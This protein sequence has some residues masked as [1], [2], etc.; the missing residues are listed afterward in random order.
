MSG[1][2]VRRRV[3]TRHRAVAAAGL[4]L[5]LCSSCVSPVEEPAAEPAV[6]PAA[7]AAAEPAPP[8]VP[9]PSEPAQTGW[10]ADQPAEWP[11]EWLAQQKSR[12]ETPAEPGPEAPV[13]RDVEAEEEAASPPGFVHGS[14]SLRYRDQETGSERDRDLYALLDLEMGDEDLDP[15]TATIVGR[16]AQDFGD[17]EP[18]FASPEDTFASNLTAQL[19]EAHIDLHDVPSLE[20]V[21]LGRQELFETPVWVRYDGLQLE[22]VP[23]G[24]G[25]QTYGFYGGQSVHFWESS[26]E[27]DAVFGAWWVDHPW[28]GGRARLD[29]MHVEDETLTG[30][31][32]DDLVAVQLR[33]DVGQSTQLQGDYSWLGQTPRDLRLGALWND[34]EEGVVVQGTLYELLSTQ[35]ELTEELDPFSPTLF[36]Q[37]PYRQLRASASKSWDDDFDLDGGADVRRVTDESDV[38][39]FNRDFE[40]YYLTATK[41]DAFTDDLSLGLTGELW[42]SGGTSQSSW[43]LDATREW[44][45]LRASLGTYY[46][47]FKN[48]FFAGE[49]RDH[50]RTWYAALRY[51]TESR[52]TWTLGYDFE[53]TSEGNFHT[54]RLGA[55]WRF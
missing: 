15:W 20:V 38:S 27:G 10:S 4:L 31:R 34:A 48:D 53:D 21:T 23:G 13:D 28:S 37:F 41:H 46:A 45:R 52:T 9:E 32:E 42:D 29:W 5:V 43:G 18:E 35:F 1:A 24:S 30:S 36:A 47:L 26:P 17:D 39:D 40:R 25:K 51:L 8:A 16:L 19:Y 6:P 14:L 54:V 2:G 50:V 44:D 22:T 3:S 55:L 7:D 49:E 12:S 33:Q 11:A